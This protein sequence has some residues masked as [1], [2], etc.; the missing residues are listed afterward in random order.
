MGIDSESFFFSQLQEYKGKIPNLISRRQYNDRRKSTTPFCQIIRERMEKKVDGW[1]NYF[2]IDSKPIEVYRPARARCCSMESTD[3]EEAPS[4]G[5]CASQG[6]YYYGYKLHALCRLGRVIH[7][8]DLTKASVHDIHYLEDVKAEYYNCTV[9]GNRGY[10][11]N[12][13]QLDL[14]ET[15]SIL[16]KV[17]YRI[18]QKE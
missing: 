2:C 3:F 7:S 13:V 4:L 14:F 5:Y 10:I 1:Q 15:A 9:I 12:E 6:V 11:S 18:N 17:P 16:L 8:F